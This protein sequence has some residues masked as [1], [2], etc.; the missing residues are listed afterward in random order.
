MLVHKE[1][2]PDNV[3]AAR[4]ILQHR[5]CGA[6]F[7]RRNH[8]I[9][10]FEDGFAVGGAAHGLELYDSDD[11]EGLVREVALWL[12]TLPSNVEYLGVWKQNGII[13]VD[14]VTY[15][16]TE[17]APWGDV[18]SRI[19]AVQLGANR[20]QKAIYDFANRRDITIA[21]EITW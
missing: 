12:S 21:D 10:D 2:Y 19:N 14:A 5:D 3:E 8:R 17:R 1:P 11:L 20:K 9:V 16:P 13:Y 7:S 15:I 6:T 4:I 18:T